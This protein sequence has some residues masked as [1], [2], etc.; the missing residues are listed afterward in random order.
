IFKLSQSK[1]MKTKLLALSLCLAAAFSAN[2][3]TAEVAQSG[4]TAF[5][6]A[7]GDITTEV[8]ISLEHGISLNRGGIRMRKFVSAD[9]AYR[10]G[11]NADYV[12]NKMAD[13][14]STRYG[15]EIE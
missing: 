3:Q 4:D 5:K 6:P 15:A 1:F 2:A 8:A 7:A 10:L 13:H 9:K 11:V 12:Y 14:T